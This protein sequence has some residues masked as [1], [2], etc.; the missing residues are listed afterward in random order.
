MAHVWGG[1]RLLDGRSAAADATQHVLPRGFVRIRQ[2][3]YLTNTRRA[4]SLALARE[5]LDASSEPAQ[6]GLTENHAA[7]VW[8][9]P[10]CNSEMRIGPNLSAHQLASQCGFLDSS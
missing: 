7:P 4:A 3:G 6:I 1:T 10:R 2:F 8:R 5:L 9:C